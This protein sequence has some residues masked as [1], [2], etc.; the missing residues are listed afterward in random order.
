MTIYRETCL[1]MRPSASKIEVPRDVRN[2]A[3]K[4]SGEE[5]RNSKCRNM[6][7]YRETCLVMRPSTS[8]IEVPRDVRNS[9]G[10]KT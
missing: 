7:I 10:P 9:K 3:E 4:K 2:S 5:Y 8:K 1:E 6:T